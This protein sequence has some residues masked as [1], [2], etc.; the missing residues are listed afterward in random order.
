MFMDVNSIF[1]IILRLQRKHA[2]YQIYTILI[3]LDGL[4]ELIEF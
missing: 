4:S 2:E 3:I 1:H